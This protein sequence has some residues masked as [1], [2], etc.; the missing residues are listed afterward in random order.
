MFLEGTK[1]GEKMNSKKRERIERIAKKF[2]LLNEEDKM[3]IDGY[4]TAKITEEKKKED[5]QQEDK[6]PA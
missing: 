6:Q 3:F 5:K 1:G 4:I 2:I